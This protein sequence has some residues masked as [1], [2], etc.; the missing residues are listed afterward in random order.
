MAVAVRPS[1]TARDHKARHA[2]KCG[3]SRLE[4]HR[5][6][7]TRFD[8]PAVITEEERVSWHWREAVCMGL[9]LP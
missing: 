6:V 4:Q 7:A 3:I 1:S 2:V 8:E 5:A 9:H